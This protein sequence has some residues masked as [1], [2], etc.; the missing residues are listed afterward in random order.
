MKF[1]KAEKLEKSIG[2]KVLWR[3]L[4][5][6]I[7]E[8]EK[9]GIVGI[10]GSGKSTL[11]KVLRGL[12]GVDAGEIISPKDY[13]IAYLSQEPTF[14][15]E[16]PVLEQVLSS[17][18]PVNETVKKYEQVTELLSE[19]PEDERLQQE[20]FRLCKEMDLLEGWDVATR[21]KTV[22][23]KLGI[24]DYHAKVGTLSG[25]QR[26][27]VA[28]AEVL[29]T[30]ADLLLLDEPTNHLDVDMID[31][32]QE[33]LNRTQEAVLFVTHDRYFLDKVAT[34]IFEIADGKLYS[35]IGNY[36]SY[37]EQKALRE[38][39]ELLRQ[40]K[41]RN[42]YRRELAWIKRGA[43][44]RSTKQKARIQRFEQLEDSLEKKVKD[45]MTL[46]AN[47]TRL[48]KD[49]IE[50]V[51]C[52]KAF[53][54]KKILD[55]F[56]LLVKPKDRIGIAGGNGCGKSTLL[57]IIAGK[58]TL[59]KGTIRIGQTVK[60]AYFT[61]DSVDL[62]DNKR[63]IEYV[64]ETRDSLQLEGKSVSASQLLERFLFPLSMQ[65]N[66]IRT[67]SGGEKKRLY[68]LKLLMEEPNVL[69]L[70]EPTND[71]DTETL[72]ILEDFLEDFQGVV[73]AVSHDRYFLDKVCDQLLIFK[74]NGVIDKY[75]G[76][77]SEYLKMAGKTLERTNQREA[78]KEEAPKASGK[79]KK[80]IS[81]L[82]KK[83]WEEIDGKIAD[84]EAKLAQIREE[85]ALSGSDYA[86][87]ENLMQEE[88]RLSGELE[89][90][91]ERWAYLSELFD[92]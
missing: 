24:Q 42:L 78:K 54:E 4:S 3:D 15:P 37:L 71:L 73:I 16:I 83:E 25:G 47:T 39:E 85:M 35:Y 59:D 18:N 23:S 9:I 31:W 22:L 48:G 1:L 89:R 10:N 8:G 33:E 19:S 69:L 36:E 17:P 74:G 6:S 50:M 56:S 34:K 27:R 29:L 46:S 11:L 66:F 49:V 72:T 28:L 41:A 80:K 12:D 32:L 61:Q 51:D 57:N 75:F 60:I 82:E 14:D 53:G 21:A 30:P 45:Q 90:L 55:H 62:D 68:L 92:S 88:Q 44:A 67:L 64:R 7:I 65:G 2:V 86:K 63:I 5:F 87:L 81:Y 13:S 20:Y 79:E 26:K 58:E 43:K 40:E 76:S 70:D 52:F 91:I 84:T 77:F 38:E